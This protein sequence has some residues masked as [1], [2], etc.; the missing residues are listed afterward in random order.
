[1]EKTLKIVLT[2]NEDQAK[3]YIH[4]VAAL[5]LDPGN[6]TEY[7]VGFAIHIDSLQRTCEQWKTIN[8]LAAAGVPV[9]LEKEK[10]YELE[11]VLEEMLKEAE[12]FVYNEKI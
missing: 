12:K 8:K 6:R 10:I 4:Q 3:K 2:L 11:S 9:T 1:M 5:G 7:S